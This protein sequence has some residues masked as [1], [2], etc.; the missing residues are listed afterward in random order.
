MS[1]G[2]AFEQAAME[3][4]RS[5]GWQID[6][7]GNNGRGLGDFIAKKDGEI[8]LVEVKYRSRL[9]MADVRRVQDIAAEVARID[10]TPR[11]KFVLAVPAGSLSPSAR[12]AATKA[13]KD[14]AVPL[15]ILE[16]P[17][18]PAFSRDH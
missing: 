12:H 17:E 14:S 6:P 7:P 16:I 10:Q 15:E 18:P 13:T 1:R 9:S 3:W 8:L 11:L 4:L 5:T 2:L